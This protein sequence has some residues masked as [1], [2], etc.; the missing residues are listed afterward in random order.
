MLVMHGCAAG[1][2]PMCARIP[3]SQ[4][5]NRYRRKGRAE[6][7]DACI[8]N[9]LLQRISHCRNPQ[10]IAHPA[11]IC[12]HAK[13]G[14]ALHMFNRCKSFQTRLPDIRCGHIMLGIDKG[15][16]LACGANFINRPDG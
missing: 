7:G 6:G 11:L 12:R 2:D 1:R 8:S 10:H 5:A 4:R 3:A 15:F 13:R 9:G 16:Q 14:V